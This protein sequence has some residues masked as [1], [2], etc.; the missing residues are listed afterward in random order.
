MPEATALS[1]AY[2]LM[3]QNSYMT[4]A[5]KD[6]G[7]Y[8]LLT[9]SYGLQGAAGQTTGA[10]APQSFQVGIPTAAGNSQ[11][12][13]NFVSNN[14]PAF[15]GAFKDQQAASTAAGMIASMEVLGQATLGAVLLLVCL[16][17]SAPAY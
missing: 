6:R 12:P 9:P 17:N 8:G 16:F 14:T 13:A 3:T 15:Q 4:Q 7:A 1:S 2:P 10:T 11:V 5:S